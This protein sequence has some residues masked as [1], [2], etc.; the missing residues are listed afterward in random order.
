MVAKDKKIEG[1]LVLN[2]D[3][4]FHGMIAGDVIIIRRGILRLYGLC[5]KNLTLEQGSKAF[6]YGTVDGNVLNRAGYL[7]VYGKINGNLHTEAG[8]VTHIDSQAV[9]QGTR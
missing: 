3:L 8:A 2:Y 6:L 4:T 1:S 9:V 5:C 7:E